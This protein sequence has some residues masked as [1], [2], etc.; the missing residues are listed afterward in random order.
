MKTKSK[1][2]ISALL[3]I[4]L[5]VSLIAGTTFA[6]FSS[7]DSVNIAVTSGKVEVVATIG[8]LNAAVL[9]NS[10][11]TGPNVA[12]SKNGNTVTLDNMT[13][14]DVVS[15]K[16][17]IKNNS[18]V[19]V[20]YRTSIACNKGEILMSGLNFTVGDRDFTGVISYSSKWADLAQNA[21]YDVEVVVALPIRGESD[22]LYQGL[23]TEIAY[24]IEAVQAN[25]AQEGEEEITKLVV[26]RN[27][28]EAQFAIDDL[29]ENTKVLLTEG[30]YDKLIVRP[31]HRSVY[32]EGGYDAWPNDHACYDRFINNVSIVGEA[33]AKVVVNGFT[34]GSTLFNCKG[35][36]SADKPVVDD[37]PGEFSRAGYYIDGITFDNIIWS[38]GIDFTEGGWA[39]VEI[40]NITVQNCITGNDN[41]HNAN[42]STNKLINSR[43]TMEN[44]VVRNCQ[45][46]NRFQGVYVQSVKNVTVTECKFTNTVHNS[47]AIQ[48]GCSGEII[49]KDNTV[50][51]C[52]DRAIRFGNLGVSN[53]VIKNNAMINSSDGAGEML[54]AESIAEGSTIVIDQNYW[55]GKT[56]LSG[57][58]V[59]VNA[60][61]ENP[62]TD[63]VLGSYDFSSV[64]QE[65]DFCPD[66]YKGING[67]HSNH[68]AYLNIDPVAGVAN[69]PYEGAWVAY[70]NLNLDNSKYV[71]TVAIDLSQLKEGSF[72]AFDCGETLHWGD[73]HLGFGRENG[74]LVA[75]NSIFVKNIATATKVVLDSD[76][77]IAEYTFDKVG[78]NLNMSLRLNGG[79]EDFATRISDV[80]G[81]NSEVNGICWDVYTYNAVNGEANL[82]AIKSLDV[83]V[84][85]K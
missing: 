21:E 85:A 62:V 11:L 33:G 19:A 65:R 69:V 52:Q 64:T 84:I 82:A 9:E 63:A 7:E 81:W 39:P 73:V 74:K 56:D 43:A 61:D 34:N 26:A 32:H 76:V 25:G 75:Y 23:T 27:T 37:K 51:D 28:E 2:L 31:S 77:V 15:F 42:V 36:P 13:P 44:L 6:L 83:Q 54:K 46:T 18:T 72:V 59:N 49:L 66:C 48:S 5:C 67:E 1:V 68:K 53:I 47:I 60:T 45:V 29:T 24:A 16:I 40:S 8:E 78:D 57:V 3:V 41:D 12:A 70:K 35:F 58:I 30:T 10:G 4:A 55:G 80:K 71:I 38:E 79:S 20:K 14:G 17:H 50:I 22:N